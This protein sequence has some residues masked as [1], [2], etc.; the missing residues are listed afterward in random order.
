ME[1]LVVTAFY[2]AIVGLGLLTAW[3]SKDL[4]LQRVSCWMGIGWI[5]ANVSF[6]L[7]GPHGA[8]WL[9]PSLNAFVAV[10]I[11]VWAIRQSSWWAWAIVALYA[12][13]GSVSLAGFI[14]HSQGE[15]L[16]YGT[17]NAIFLARWF[18]VAAGSVYVLVDRL[19]SRRDSARSYRPSRD[20]G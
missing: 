14:S 8:P 7:L 4:A 13:E 10:M 1:R 3:R 16:Y 2:G 18:V 17:L 15:P 9:T 20:F 6:E 19:V 5:G 11:A 12:I